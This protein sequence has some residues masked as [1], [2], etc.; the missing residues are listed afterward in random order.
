V[1]LPS[2]LPSPAAASD[3]QDHQQPGPRAQK[4]WSERRAW[5]S[6]P[7]CRGYRHNGFQDRR[8]RPLCEPSTCGFT[9]IKITCAVLVRVWSADPG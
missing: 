8:T 9:V 5:D 7:R 2:V 3:S 4:P 1:T 6:N